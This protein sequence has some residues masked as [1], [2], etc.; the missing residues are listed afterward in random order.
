MNKE[1]TWEECI[2]SSSSISISSDK[3]KARSLLDTA[4]GRNKFLEGNKVKE[5]NAN[6][7][8]EGYYSS[9]LEMLRAL[10]LLHG[11]KVENHICL[12]YYL[13]DILNKNNLYRLFDDCRYK[14]NSLIYYGRKMEFKTAKFTI[15]KCKNLIK[16]LDE[17]VK[18]EL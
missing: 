5:D 8:F 7:I 12:G 6:Y 4:N 9:A 16:E 13:R 15:D 1:S 14:R 3:A 17:I 2:E 10:L 18:R 11:Y